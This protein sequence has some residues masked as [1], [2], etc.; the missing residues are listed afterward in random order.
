VAKIILKHKSGSEV[1]I[2][3]EGTNSD[4]VAHVDSRIREVFDIPPEEPIDY[5]KKLKEKDNP[6]PFEQMFGKDN[7]FS[8]IFGGSK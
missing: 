7:P 6:N 8:S 1:I 3:I 2:Y 5:L 4:L